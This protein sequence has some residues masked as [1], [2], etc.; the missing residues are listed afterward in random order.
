MEDRSDRKIFLPSHRTVFLKRVLSPEIKYF[1]YQTFKAKR[2]F[3]Q[4]S[5]CHSVVYLVKMESGHGDETIHLNS[6][7][8]Y[9]LSALF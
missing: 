1:L 5:K 4:R 3:Y 8:V 9:R 6:S 2:L 7:L